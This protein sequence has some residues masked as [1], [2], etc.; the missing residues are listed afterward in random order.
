MIKGY[1]KQLP[2]CSIIIRNLLFLFLFFAI[3]T[4]TSAQSDEPVLIT[5]NFDGVTCQEL[6]DKL[7]SSYGLNFYYKNIELP[8]KQ[9]SLSF[10]NQPVT[11]VLDAVFLGSSIS[12]VTYRDYAY[13]VMPE[14]VVNEVYTTDYYQRVQGLEDIQEEVKTLSV[15]GDI[16]RLDPS[17]NATI[18]GKIIDAQTEEDIIGANIVWTETG[19]G[20][21]TDIN[22]VF[23]MSV[24]AGIREL[25]VGYLGYQD[26]LQEYNV[27]S[28]GETRIL[29]EKAAVNLDEVTITGEAPDA[30]VEN[31]Q[32]GVASL[33]IKNI[34]KLPSFMGETDVVK[35]L[36]LSAGVSSI[37]E[38]SG[39]FNVRG[40]DV[41][42]NL[43]Q[44]DEGFLFN[45][46][47]ALGFFSTF[48]SDLI[49]KVD[50]FKGNIPAQYGGRL[51]S[52][53]DVRMRNGNFN[54]FKIKGS[55]GPVSSKI[56]FEGPI[57]SEKTSFIGGFRSS[58]T[59]WVLQRINNDEI[60]N[61]SAF[62]TDMNLRLTHKFDNRNS[63]SISGYNSKDKFIYNKEFGFEYDTKMAQLELKNSLANNLIS[64][65]SVTGSKYES[66]QR[67]LQ[68]IDGSQLD[69]NIS[70]IKIKEQLTYFKDEKV[71]ID[72][73]VSAIMYTIDPGSRFPFG[74]NTEIEE[75]ILEEEKSR[76]SSGFLNLEYGLSDKFLISGGVRFSLYQ[77]LGP[78][79][80]YQYQ[81]PDRPESDEILGS[82]IQE[83]TIAD[84][85]SL[86]PRVSM[87][88]KL[89]DDLSFKAGYSRTAQFINQVFNTDSPTPTSQWQLSNTY[90]EPNRSHNV[91]VGLFRNFNDNNV[92]T[93]IEVYGRKIDQLYDYRDFAELVV[94]DHIETELLFGEGRSYG[95]ELSLK[96]KVG[97]LN[98]S[99]A[100]TFSK[101]EKLIEGINGGAYFP[102]NFDKT[103]DAS[104]LLNYQ[105][106]QRNTLT[107]NFAYST[108]RPTTAPIGNYITQEGLVVPIFSER[109]QLRIP[110]YHRLDFA[111]TLGKG[112]KEQKFRTSWTFGIYNIYGRRNAFSVYFTQ[113][114]FGRP[115]ANKL[116][117]LG[118]AFPS[119]T[120]NIELL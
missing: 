66:I 76:E 88:Y 28:S 7:S 8:K 22:G 16:D 63:L 46:S 81:N 112:Y 18:T 100:Y 92:E 118:S 119:L 94:N 114:G 107:F 6:L 51:A 106:N 59:D 38:G 5:E 70:Y 32:V 117:V 34:E 79:N 47:H 68:G 64:N 56:M 77:Y 12:Y 87:R 54:K 42:Q 103:H 45:S 57:I 85:T 25:K 97:T 86:E 84:Y 96:K 104:F 19:Q 108:G 21:I 48:N 105:P 98:G 120:L 72:A 91:S 43:I 99:F 41:D 10:D 116:S 80:V 17:G 29:L 53:M 23:T 4:S 27:L 78:Q 44:Q 93:S 90:I 24:P 30:Q 11:E 74:D 49:S 95:V 50:L 20:T 65:L 31:V 35:S 69:N 75:K 36:L 111:Y 3:N 15:I 67:D 61:S 109:N 9:Y 89:T 13:V 113:D 115:V 62:F 102:S 101:S 83:G 52:V 33:D 37:G 73:G 26:Y 110:A 40:G 14:K 82:A 60:K 55:V 1:C 2:Q 58:Y 39:G 71:K